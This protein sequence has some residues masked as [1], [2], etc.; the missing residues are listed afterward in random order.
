M[1]LRVRTKRAIKIRSRRCTKC[2]KALNRQRVRCT[3]C[4]KS[5][6]G[7]PKGKGKVR[8]HVRPAQEK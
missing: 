6:P 1:G 7:L 3:V 2:G 5:Q 8:P 4:H